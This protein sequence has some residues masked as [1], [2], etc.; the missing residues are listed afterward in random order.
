MNP[1]NEKT[2]DVMYAIGEATPLGWGDGTLMT[3]IADGQF[4]ILLKSSGDKKFKF[5]PLP[6]SGTTTWECNIGENFGPNDIVFGKICPTLGSTLGG[7]DEYCC[8]IELDAWKETMKG[9]LNNG[10]FR[11]LFFRVIPSK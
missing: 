8:K 11:L 7:T 9:I 5:K 6:G 2:K 1:C 4:E 10:F 3:K